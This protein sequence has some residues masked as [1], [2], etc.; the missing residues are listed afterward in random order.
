MRYALRSLAVV[1]AFLAPTHATAGGMNRVYLVPALEECIGNAPCPRALQSRYTFEAIV[2][3]TPAARYLAKGKPPLALTVKGVRD[4]AGAPVNGNLRLRV[5]PSRVSVPGFGTFP[6]DFPLP[7][8]RDSIPLKNGSNKLFSYQP[9]PGPGPDTLVNGGGVEI[10]DPEGKLLAV[11]G[12]Q[13]K[14]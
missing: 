11:T 3:R 6:D 13:T 7:E 4:P 12:S 5:L 2:L 1:A 14:P 8:Q 10:Y 9:E